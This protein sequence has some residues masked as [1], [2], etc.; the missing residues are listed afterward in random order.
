VGD[1]ILMKDES[2]ASCDYRLG[3][4]V[5]VFPGEDGHVRRVIVTYKNPGEAVFR[6]SERPI[7]K[8]VL[9]VPAK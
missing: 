3:R 7:H 1:V 6:K 5:E 9:I 2:I 8:L 4:V